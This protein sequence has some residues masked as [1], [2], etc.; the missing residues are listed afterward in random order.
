V[1]ESLTEFAS[2]SYIEH[3]NFTAIMMALRMFEAVERLAL[4]FSID[5]RMA[6]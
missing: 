3:G 5:C 1:N 6:E 2:T 4:S